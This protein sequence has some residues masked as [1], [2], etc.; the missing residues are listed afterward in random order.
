MVSTLSQ[1]ARACLLSLAFPCCWNVPAQ[2]LEPSKALTQYVQE[3][4]QQEE[5]LPENDVTAII[6]TRDGYIWL[7][8]EEGLVRFDGVRFTVFDRSNTPRLTSP[9]I[10]SLLEGRDGSLWIGTSPGGGLSAERR[11]VQRLPDSGWPFE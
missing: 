10:T 7:G 5:C 4:W 2:A 1:P 6:Q 9:Y 3:V 11:Q 8:T